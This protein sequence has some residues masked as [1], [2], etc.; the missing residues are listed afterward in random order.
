MTLV[1]DASTEPEKNAR[2]QYHSYGDIRPSPVAG[3]T[4]LGEVSDPL[5]LEH[6]RIL[7]SARNRTSNGI[8]GIRNKQTYVYSECYSKWG[9][10][11]ATGESIFFYIM[12]THTRVRTTGEGRSKI[13][14]TIFVRLL[15]HLAHPPLA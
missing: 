11:L 1:Y 12:Q 3:Q 14:P 8:R 15:C 13:A 9:T 7:R 4:C 2:A 6:N 5:P 10:Y